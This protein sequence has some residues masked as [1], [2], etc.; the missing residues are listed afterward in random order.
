MRFGDLTEDAAPIG[1]AAKLVAL[2]AQLRSSEGSF[3]C[4]KKV[5]ANQSL[6]R[7]ITTLHKQIP[8]PQKIVYSMKRKTKIHKKS[9][10]IHFLFLGDPV[11]SII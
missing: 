3:S 4:R 7:T 10:V 8:E 1:A 11:T 9:K 5:D 2:T 6:R